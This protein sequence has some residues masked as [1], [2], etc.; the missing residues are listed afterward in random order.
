VLVV[1]KAKNG[2]K[3]SGPDGYFMVFF[4]VCLVILKEDIMKV[5]F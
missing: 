2:D 5:F 4:Q 1:V 3:A